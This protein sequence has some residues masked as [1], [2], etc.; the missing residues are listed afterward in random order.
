MLA[1][2]GLK[3]KYT[4]KLFY[5]E[6]A[7]SVKSPYKDDYYDA[8][9]KETREEYLKHEGGA[10][11]GWL[12]Y[13]PVR[14][15]L[16][17]EYK[18]KVKRHVETVIDG[19]KTAFLIPYEYTT[20]SK[21]VTFY[22]SK[23]EQLVSLLTNTPHLFSE[24]SIPYD[25]NAHNMLFEYRNKNVLVRKLF[26][27]KYRFRIEMK[28]SRDYENLDNRVAMV[29]FKD[30]SYSYGSSSRLLFVSD[31]SDLFMAK[32]ALGDEIEKIVECKQ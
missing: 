4:Q 20:H 11:T 2:N 31:E 24:Y 21:S 25:D 5:G 30:S 13:V 1:P 23:K 27:G 3:Q 6:F 19:N 8:Y 18:E 9:L 7:Y 16:K 32:L 10:N 29:V 17:V 14:N 22:L 15:R 28:K 12:K 26:F